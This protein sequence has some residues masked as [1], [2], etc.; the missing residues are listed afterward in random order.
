[1]WLLASGRQPG[2][3]ADGSRLSRT[4]SSRHKSSC[5]AERVHAARAWGWRA[6]GEG[7]EDAPGARGVSSPAPPTGA[8]FSRPRIGPGSVSAPGWDPSGNQ[9]RGVGARGA[10]WGPQLRGSTAAPAFRRTRAPGGRFRSVRWRPGSGW[11][12]RPRPGCPKLSFL[13][14]FSASRTPRVGR[15]GFVFHPTGVGNPRTSAPRRP[16]SGGTSTPRCD[17]SRRRAGSGAP[18]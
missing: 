16:R 14:S 5:Q 2:L 12:R 13:S 8:Q 7:R 15:P 3:H 10:G 1:M 17:G 4:A 6:R 18:G 11:Q 9:A